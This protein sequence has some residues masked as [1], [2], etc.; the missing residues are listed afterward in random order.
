MASVVAGL[1]FGGKWK[2]ADKDAIN[3]S[4]PTFLNKVK[5]LS[6]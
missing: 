3:T 5:Y 1:C 6:S 2:I 4:F